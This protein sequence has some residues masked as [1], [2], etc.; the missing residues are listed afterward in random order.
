M[1]QHL[2]LLKSEEIAQKCSVLKVDKSQHFSCVV[3]RAILRYP[4]S[5][6]Y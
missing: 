6:F 4:G 3:E 2:D 5:Q 1:R